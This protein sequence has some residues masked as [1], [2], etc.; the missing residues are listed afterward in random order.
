MHEFSEN[1]QKGEGH[2]QSKICVADFGSFYRAF[3]WTFPETNLQH[4]F[5]KMGG[6]VKGRLN[7]F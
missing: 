6:G 1:V 2:F 7:F 5:P 4:N 3:F